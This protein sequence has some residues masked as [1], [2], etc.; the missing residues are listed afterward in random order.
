MPCRSG[1]LD[2]G[3]DH[4]QVVEHDRR[5]LVGILEPREHDHGSGPTGPPRW[6]TSSVSAEL[7]EVRDGLADLGLRRPVEHDADRALLRVLEDEHD[8]APEEVGQP[9][10]GHEQLSPYGIHAGS[11]TWHGARRNGAR[12][13]ALDQDGET[14]R[15]LPTCAGATSS[16]TSIRRP[17][18]RGARRRRAA[19]AT[20]P[21]TTSA[22][23]PSCAAS[24]PTRPRNCPQVRR[25]ARARASRF[26]RTRTTPSPTHSA[27][28]SRSRCTAR[29]TGERA[30]DLRHRP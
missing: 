5:R 30:H 29:S 4:A 10:R 2:A 20:G 21:P 15:P 8:G 14:V 17:T 24:R 22:R 19:C 3:V 13:R 6:T 9:G 26:S 27:S 18:R 16:S 7:R 12:L 11:V 28:G 25:Q 1:C 23:T